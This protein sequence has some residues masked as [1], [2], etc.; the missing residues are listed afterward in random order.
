MPESKTR[1]CHKQSAPWNRGR[2]RRAA[3]PQHPA[4]GNQRTVFYGRREHGEVSLSVGF[5][6]QV[7]YGHPGNCTHFCRDSRGDACFL[8]KAQAIT[9]DII[10]K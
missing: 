3:A 7:P 6:E 4:R 1:I 8:S 10:K 2:E 5:L 9:G